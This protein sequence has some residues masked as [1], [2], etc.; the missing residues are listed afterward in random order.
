MDNLSKLEL[1][2]SFA[3]PSRN[4]F[5]TSTFIGPS[6]V[7]NRVQSF[8]KESI[9]ANVSCLSLNLFN[10][11]KNSISEKFGSRAFEI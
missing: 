8:S 11:N 10:K 3:L 9:D 2:Q 1:Y 4:S 7:L 6:D 5:K